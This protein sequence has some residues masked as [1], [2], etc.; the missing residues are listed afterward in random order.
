M[1]TIYPPGY[2]YWLQT[3]AL[4]HTMMYGSSCLQVHE[5]PQSH[6]AIKKESTYIQIYVHIY[7]HVYINIYRYEYI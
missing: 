7:I 3:H 5:L 2:H 6:W 4:G 1:K